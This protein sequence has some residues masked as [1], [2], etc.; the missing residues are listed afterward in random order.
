M[1]G[2]ILIDPST[3]RIVLPNL[4][5][6]SDFDL[7]AVG[8]MTRGQIID[9]SMALGLARSTDTVSKLLIQKISDLV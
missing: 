9:A 5:N 3:H 4:E 7:F 2:S 6:K 1:G 8:A